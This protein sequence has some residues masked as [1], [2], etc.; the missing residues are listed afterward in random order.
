MDVVIIEQYIRRAADFYAG[1][2]LTRDDELYA[3]S[4]ALLAIHSAISYSDALRVSLGDDRLSADDHQAAVNSLDTLLSAKSFSDSTGLAHL[5]FL[6][7]KK[8]LVS[9]G[10]KRNDVN[11]YRQIILKAERF[12]SWVSSVGKHLE[13]EGWTNANR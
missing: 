4:A 3:N 7:A 8:S 9:Y 11:T 6:V 13:L 2:E 12:A 5:R 10:T 1:M